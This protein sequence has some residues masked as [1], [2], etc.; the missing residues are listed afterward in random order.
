MVF[1]DDDR[2]AGRADAHFVLEGRC[3]CVQR[4]HVR[5]TTAFGRDRFTLVR[6]AAGRDDV[7]TVFV[8]MSK[9]RVGSA[10]GLG[11]YD[12]RE[13]GVARGRFPTGFPGTKNPVFGN[14][15]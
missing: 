9:L 15:F 3:V 13:G 8:K 4:L 12:A 7:S 5:K 6:D 2:D 1:A 10:F 14:F 11:E